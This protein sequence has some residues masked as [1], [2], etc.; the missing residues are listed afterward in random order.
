MRLRLNPQ[1]DTI[2]SAQVLES[3]DPLFELPTTG[4]IVGNRFYFMANTQIHN[5]APDGSIRAG[6][7]FNPIHVLRLNLDRFPR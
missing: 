6:M 5:I 4:A 1:R 2:V 3:Y 7:H